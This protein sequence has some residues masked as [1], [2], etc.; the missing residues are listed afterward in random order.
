MKKIT[1]TEKVMAIS[2]FLWKYFQKQPKQTN[3]TQTDILC[4]DCFI[5]LNSST[6]L[7]SPL[8]SRSS[9]SSGCKAAHCTKLHYCRH[10]CYFTNNIFRTS[11]WFFF[12]SFSPHSSAIESVLPKPLSRQNNSTTIRKIT[13]VLNHGKTLVCLPD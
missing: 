8:K 7:W 4:T 6:V 5:P 11:L 10:T 2:L 1:N 12:F 3:K 13:H 9:Q